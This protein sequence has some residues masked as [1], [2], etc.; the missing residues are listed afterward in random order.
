MAETTGSLK[1][2]TQ[3]GD[4]VAKSKVVMTRNLG[5]LD[6]IVSNGNLA[7]TTF[8]QQF[9]AGERQ[10]EDNKWD[11]TREAADS[12]I[13]PHY[14]DQL[15]FAALSL[16]GIGVKYYGS[17]HV[18]FKEHVIE[19]RSSVF[20]ENPS[21]FLKKHAIVVGDLPP[22]GYRADW[23]SRHLLAQA[24]LYAQIT[25]ATKV[26]TYPAI[27]MDQRDGFDA[28]F[29]EVHIFGSLNRNSIS[30]VIATTL[31]KGPERHIWRNVKRHLENIGVE[32]EEQ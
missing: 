4:E 19:Q 2:F 9:R 26:E 1:Q 16:D 25:S 18:E 30:K 14:H 17:F 23:Q 11:R 22:R 10:P 7:M 8:Y 12:T 6:K 31:P 5:P 13:N 24:K 32:V 15:H 3:F 28:D 29:V 27:L 20:E 21:L